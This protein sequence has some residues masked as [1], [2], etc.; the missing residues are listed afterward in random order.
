[1]PPLSAQVAL[2]QARVNIQ[3][4]RE[5]QDSDRVIEHYQTAKN[6]L[7]KVD[8]AKADVESLTEM[9][10]GFEDLAVILDNWDVDRAVKCRKRAG[11]LRKKLD[12][13]NRTIKAAIDLSLLGPGLPQVAIS[14]LSGGATSTV[15]PLSSS[16]AATIA[17]SAS[18][19]DGTSDETSDD[20]SD[21]RAAHT[22]SSATRQQTPSSQR[23]TV[24]VL[25]ATGLATNPM[26][27]SKKAA[28][29]SLNWRLSDPDKQLENTR[30]L[31][32]CLALL[33]EPID[34]TLLDSATLEWRLNT[35]EH[36]GERRRLETLAKDIV[37]AFFED[38]LKDADTVAEVIQVAPA[39][40]KT[41]FRS[42]LNIL[43][44]TVSKSELLHLHAMEGLARVIQGAIP[45]SIDSDDLVALLQVLYVRLKTIHTPSSRHLCQLL[46]A[47]SQVLDAMVVAQV[48]DVT[49]VTLHEPLTVRLHELELDQDRYVAFQAKYATQ[50]LLNVSDDDTIWR[51]GFRRGWLVMR[52][53][54][55][56]AKMPD[57]RDIK[58]VLEGLEKVCQ[59]VK[60]TARFFSNTQ[61][62]IE[63]REMPTFNAKEGLKF[64]WI[65]Y[66]TLRNAEEYIQTGDL[67]RF[68]ELHGK[69]RLHFLKHFVGM[70]AF[71]PDRREYTS[72]PDLAG[73]VAM[74]E[75]CT[76][77][78]LQP[79]FASL[80]R[81]LVS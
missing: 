64:K 21:E 26:P 54:A 61:E 10:A 58:D 11:I 73:E 1:M 5:A 62:A 49:R 69:A 77:T 40:D 68:Q 55:G 2:E 74:A 38:P 35:K 37:A 48:G 78:A 50:A 46:F 6:V 27:F 34:E 36:P 79:A 75:L 14:S 22:A 67:I 76:C 17:P 24:S 23:A 29:A 52:G 33:Q 18:T 9:V 39:L 71:G 56:F 44:E 19:S 66:P 63:S 65:W 59:V 8:V 72:C 28:P 25:A 41:S 51:A 45:G 81:H 3:A 20:T 47:T 13:R 7:T 31:A 57:P 30:Q 16:T 43:V 42:L 80:E 60:G 70:T 53:A 12:K 4:S 15:A 32:Y